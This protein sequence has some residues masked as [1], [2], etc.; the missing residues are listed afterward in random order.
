MKKEDRGHR[1]EDRGERAQER[2]RNKEGDKQFTQHLKQRQFMI[3][4]KT[5]GDVMLQQNTV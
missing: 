2:E 5:N 3:D 4:S 1:T